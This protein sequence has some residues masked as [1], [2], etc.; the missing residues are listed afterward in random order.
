MS[1]GP[2]ALYDDD[3]TYGRIVVEAE[4]GGAPG[5][6]ASWMRFVVQDE[7]TER[8]MITIGGENQRVGINDT[9]PSY[10]LDV[11]GTFRATGDINANGNIVGDGSTAISSMASLGIG[12]VTATGTVQAEHLKSTD[13][14]EVGDSIYHSGDTNTKISFTT[15]QIDFTA[16]NIAMLKLDET[17]Q[18]I[19]VINEGSADVDFRV[20]NNVNSY[21]L[22]SNGAR[23]NTFIGYGS[24]LPS[25]ILDSAGSGDIWTSQ[26][27]QIV[28]GESAGS[29]GLSTAPATGHAA[30]GMYYVGNGYGY[31]G[32]GGTN[33]GT[34]GIPNQGYIRWFYNST[35][36]YVGG[37]LSKASGTFTIKHPDPAKSSSMA[38][39]HS[40][41]ESPTSISSVDLRCSA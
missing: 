16:G 8:E 29:D 4:A 41:V 3:Y 2:A 18:N 10:T 27:A 22:Y 17:T 14:I 30:I 31:V 11:A 25:L 38:L 12:S 1:T 28:I 32:M 15:D 19:V 40:F 9:T 7:G 39:Q 36:V 35:A 34:A 26:G 23:T 6:W 37:A 5:A 21:G 24:S 33:D 20:E 13:D